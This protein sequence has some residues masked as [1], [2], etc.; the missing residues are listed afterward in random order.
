MTNI[1]IVKEPSQVWEKETWVRPTKYM[2]QPF[3]ELKGLELEAAVSTT[4]ADESIYAIR[5]DCLRKA[6]RQPKPGS[7]RGLYSS[8]RVWQDHWNKLGLLDSSKIGIPADCC[9]VLEDKQ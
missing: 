5:T 9:E 3:R 4:P 2:E 6:L 1:K 7:R 8:A